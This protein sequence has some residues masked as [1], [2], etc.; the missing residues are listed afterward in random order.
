M[1]LLS[2]SEN[3]IDLKK[4]IETFRGSLQTRKDNYGKDLISDIG[5]LI[6]L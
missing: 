5:Y 4:T 6:Y 1:S 3:L 2:A